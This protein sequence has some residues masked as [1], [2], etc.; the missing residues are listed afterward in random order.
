MKYLR[1][2][3]FASLCLLLPACALD[4]PMGVSQDPKTGVVTITD[5]SG[6]IVGKIA[7]GAQTA[8]QVAGGPTN[9][10]GLIL[11]GVGSILSLGVHVYQQVR[12]KDWKGATLATAAGVQDFV[13]KMDAA[14][15]QNP[16]APSHAADL[17]KAAIDAAHDSHDVPQLLQNVLT[18]TT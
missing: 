10:V 13:G 16:I 11:W 15:S 14:H 1:V 18:P 5:P 12:V 2:V 17:L 3:A 4:G 6:G 7:T 9:P 8:S